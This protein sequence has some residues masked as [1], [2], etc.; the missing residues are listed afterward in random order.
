MGQAQKRTLCHPDGQKSCFACCPP[1]RPP[2]YEHVHH[3]SSLVR[4][5]ADNTEHLARRVHAPRAIVGYSCWALGFLD[6]KGRTIGCLLHP[7]KNQG[8][9]LRAITGYGPKC[10]R[11]L[12]P[13]ALNFDH[14]SGSSQ[15]CLLGMTKDMDSFVY[16]SPSLNPLF[17]LL[18]WGSTIA[19]TVARNE[20]HR[21]LSLTRFKGRYPALNRSDAGGLAYLAEII[22]ERKGPEALLSPDLTEHMR[23]CA[24]FLEEKAGEIMGPTTNHRPHVNTMVAPLTLKR[25][26]RLGLGLERL[27]AHE[28]ALFGQMAREILGTH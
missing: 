19:R 14:L 22:I 12:C 11:E 23:R 28:A 5:L 9:D 15:E 25:F 6:K 24:G 18:S 20:N 2:A 17:A 26:L 10:Q 7:A 13:Q 16:S 4:L 27:H 8:R 1:I 21:P 3:R